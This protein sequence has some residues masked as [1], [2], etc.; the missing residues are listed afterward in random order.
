MELKWRKSESTVM[1]LELDHTSSPTTVYMRKNIT[2]TE[3]DGQIFYEYD[4]AKLSNFDYQAY[5]DKLNAEGIEQLT[6][7]NQMLVD[8]ILEMS[9]IIYGG[10]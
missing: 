10:E 3:R 6:E 1:P 4:E 5:G 8:C 7:E 2:Q 9:E